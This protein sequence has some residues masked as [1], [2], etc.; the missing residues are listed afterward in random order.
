MDNKQSEKKIIYRGS[1][2]LSHSQVIEITHNNNPNV[3]TGPRCFPA[4]EN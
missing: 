1:L 4:L 3:V 2:L